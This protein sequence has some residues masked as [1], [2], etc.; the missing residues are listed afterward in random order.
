MVLGPLPEHAPLCEAEKSRQDENMLDV[1]S[2]YSPVQQSMFPAPSFVQYADCLTQVTAAAVC[3]DKLANL[4]EAEP[5]E[6]GATNRKSPRRSR[7]YRC[8]K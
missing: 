4:R 6:R 3:R 1:Q 8:P 2:E 5:A 7:R